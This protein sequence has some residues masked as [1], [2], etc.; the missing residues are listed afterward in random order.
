MVVANPSSRSRD[1]GITAF[2]GLSLKRC[3]YPEA[4]VARVAQL[5]LDSTGQGHC[6]T[7]L[8][9]RVWTG[10]MRVELELEKDIG[11]PVRRAEAAAD[12][13]AVL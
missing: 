5:P 13:A 2:G 6:L 10:G 9:T 12:H 8:A 1:Q 7:A 11:G 3:S 4:E